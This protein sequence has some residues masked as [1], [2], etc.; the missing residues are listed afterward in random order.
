MNNV[1]KPLITEQEEDSVYEQLKDLRP[2]FWLEG[3]Q[4]AQSPEHHLKLSVKYAI[5]A[6]RLFRTNQRFYKG[7]GTIT[8]ES[9]L[10]TLFCP[11]DEKTK[12]P[13]G[14]IG[15]YILFAR[16]FVSH[17][18]PDLDEIR[19]FFKTM[20]DIIVELCHDIAELYIIGFDNVKECFFEL[21]GRLII[22]SE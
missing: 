10:S 5:E 1:E 22:Q 12:L 6:H 11:E 3:N 9:Y 7:Q 4:N 19:I 16:A 17:P 21:A 20:G 18:N 15:E 8:P 2:T 13:K 14:L